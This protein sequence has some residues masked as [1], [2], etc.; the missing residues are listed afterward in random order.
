MNQGFSP[1]VLSSRLSRRLVLAATAAAGPALAAARFFPAAAQTPVGTPAPTIGP[2]QS[3]AAIATT[4]TADA[5]PRFR[6]VAAALMQGM[7]DHA[8][9][10]A[11]LGILMDG[12]EEH[13]V[14]GV[15]NLETN[16][17]VTPET[18][19]QAG[20]ITKTF[21]GTA[22][23]RLIAQGKLDLYA[24]VRT[25]LPDFTL[26]DD[27]VAA[28]VTVRHLLTHTAGWWGDAFF[29]TG[30]GDD[31]VARFV[32]ERLPTL[33]QIFPLG[34]MPS[35]NN[36][37]I[38]LLGRLIE[39]ATGEDYRA[40][41][42]R[43]LLD[44]LAMT[45]STFAPQQVER[46]SYAL[47]YTSSPAGTVRQSPLYFPRGIDPA[48]GL[49]STT[50]EQLQYA[51]LH[52][53][54]GVTPAGA[55]LL[56]AYTTR[57]MRLPQAWFTGIANMQVGLTWFVQEFSGVRLATHDG[58]TWGQH[59]SLLLAPEQGFALILL[60]NIE[61]GGGGA[62]PAVL[63][64]AGQEYLGLGEEAAQIGMTDGPNFAPDPAPLSLAAEELADYA[65]RYATPDMAAILRVA[66]GQLLLSIE[67]PPVPDLIHPAIEGP[68]LRDV[69]V[70]VI[71]GE[72]LAVGSFLVGAIVR[73]PSGEIGWL[74]LNI[75][76]LPRVS[77][78]LPQPGDT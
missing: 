58:H 69:P 28:R 30:D 8:I 26:A 50:R 51:R 17:P 3:P 48:G 65:G 76:T 32:R 66:N 45:A 62:D 52:L 73:K 57:L 21:T 46:G 22:I 37:A 72:R 49:W 25:Y 7:V 55:R 44:P 64:A 42:R 16:E 36:A 6:A 34:M 4:L 56:P 1:Q 68:P 77:D 33:P 60:T 59:A 41:M 10:G 5:S 70:S 47:G 12:Q 35:Y 71:S 40:A 23:M 24:P 74:R 29:D 19:F 27:S 2:W 14:F 13:A 39:V 31:A 53:A 9:P 54:D 67:H 18:L 20:S 38:V 61:T 43:L 63:T 11:A 75:L 78:G 15:A